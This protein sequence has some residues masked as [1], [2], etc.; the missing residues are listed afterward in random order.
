MPM[1]SGS[2]SVLSDSLLQHRSE[3][4][5][6]TVDVVAEL[7]PLLAAGDRPGLADEFLVDAKHFT[8]RGDVTDLRRAVLL[9]AIACEVKAKERLEEKAS[10]DAGAL[11]SAVLG[12][13]R[14]GVNFRTLALFDS[15]AK[16]VVGRSLRDDDR[17]LFNR[18]EKLFELR[19]RVAHRGQAPERAAAWDAVAAAR[20]AFDWLNGL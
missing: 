16:S 18:V 15:L 4:S 14:S 11:L 1:D 5:A 13:A 8:W 17:P 19:N 6:L 3:E 7:A 9:A 20:Q 2:A 10:T 12:G